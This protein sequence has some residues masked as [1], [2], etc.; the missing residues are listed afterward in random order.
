MGFEIARKMDLHA[1][2]SKT[3]LLSTR[4]PMVEEQ[5]C[6]TETESSVIKWYICYFDQRNYILP[7]TSVT[8]KCWAANSQQNLQQLAKSR[9][10]ESHVWWRKAQQSQQANQIA[11]NISGW[12]P[13]WSIKSGVSKQANTNHKRSRKSNPTICDVIVKNDFLMSVGAITKD[14][15]AITADVIVGE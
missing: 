9:G 12:F 3:F 15:N 5:Y 2:F 6:Y 4:T 8:H 1:K 14:E 10:T 13:L 11:Y 7:H